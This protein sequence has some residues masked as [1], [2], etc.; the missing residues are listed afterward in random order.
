MQNQVTSIF[1]AINAD[2]N[3]SAESPGQQDPFV[4]TNF[5]NAMLMVRKRI[6][7]DEAKKERKGKGKGKGKKG[8]EGE[9]GDEVIRS[10]GDPIPNPNIIADAGQS[11]NTHKRNLLKNPMAM[12]LLALL[13]NVRSELKDATLISDLPYLA[14][15]VNGTIGGVSAEIR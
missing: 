5:D 7:D 9:E 1:F 2:L 12:R 13:N 11:L 10:K 15:S 4:T 6:K 8:K 14:H 3:A